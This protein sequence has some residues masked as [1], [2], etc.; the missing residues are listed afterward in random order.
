[1]FFTSLLNISKLD[2][3]SLSSWGALIPVVAWSASVLTFVYCMII[4]FKAFFGK[5]KGETYDRKLFDAPIGML[6]SPVI[7]ALFVVCIF[8]FPNVV[9]RHLIFPALSNVFPSFSLTAGSYTIQAWHGWNTE[10]WMTIGIVLLGSLLYLTFR[11]WKGIYRMFPEHLSF[12][13]L[14]NHTLSGLETGSAKLTKRYMTGY[15]RDYLVYIYLFFIAII[16]AVLLF[17]GAFSWDVSGDSTLTTY[18]WIFIIVMATAAFA[19]LFAKSRITAILLNSVLGFSIAFFFVLFRAP[20]LALTQTII[21][22]VTTV[23]FMLCFYFLPEWKKENTP[24]RAKVINMMISVGVGLLFIAVG[25]SVN[26]G[27]LAPSISSFF[28]NAYELAGGK[29]IVNAILGDFR[30]FDTMLEV[31]VLFIAGIGVYSVIKLGKRGRETIEED[32]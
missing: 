7:L 4:V 12:D 11:Y 15:L 13:A 19:I 22:T 9:G 30:A 8:F 29:N 20:D 26:S 2:I 1:M 16:G 32:K 18:E 28:E 3:F 10:L 21:E 27:S 25:L 31:T 17:M 5:Y 23:L 6:I 14:Y 24:K